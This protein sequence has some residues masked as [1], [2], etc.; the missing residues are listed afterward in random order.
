MNRYT[1]EW[2]D[3]YLDEIL[4]KIGSDYFPLPIKLE[5]F[6]TAT[7]D[8]LK[9][10]CKNIE[11]TQEVSDDI[12]SLIKPKK[13]SVLKSTISIHS[14][15]IWNVAE[16]IDYYRLIGL[17]PLYL[18]NGEEIAKSKKISIAKTGQIEAFHRDPFREPTAEYPIVT[19]TSNLFSIY[20]GNDST[21]YTSAIITY[22]KKP[23]FASLEQETKRIVDL[24]DSAIEQIL[25]KTSN[26]L[27]FGVDD[28]N[29]TN[30]FQFN[31]QFGEYNK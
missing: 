12:K 2:C 6:I 29:A 3:Q 13:V 25:L 27:R 30:N 20:V 4:D 5:R 14:K 7:Y 31:S 28:E 15:N 23:E 10:R 16:P 18:H 22:V 19:R 24:P 21:N 9:D 11:I 1:L 8:F 17:V 26:Y